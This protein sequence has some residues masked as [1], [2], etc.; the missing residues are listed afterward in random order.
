MNLKEDYHP[1]FGQKKEKFPEYR[2]PK[3]IDV[4]NYV[5]YQLDSKKSQIKNEKDEMLTGVATKLVSIW[6]SVYV[7]T[8][9][10][11]SVTQLIKDD[12]VAEIL[13][14]VFGNFV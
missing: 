9:T 2:F 6:K 12:I 10:I 8:R 3:R 1:L 14:G 13:H 4:I 11:K 5:R 7:K